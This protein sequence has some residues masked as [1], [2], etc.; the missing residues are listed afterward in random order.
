ATDSTLKGIRTSFDQQAVTVTAEVTGALK[1]AFTDAILRVYF[2]GMFVVVAG[3][4]VTLFLP[5]L[6][7]RK[8]SGASVVG[9]SE[10]GAAPSAGP[11]TP[12]PAA[13][14]PPPTPT[15]EEA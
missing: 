6:A 1:K 2:W 8:R 13:S 5:E 15:S 7:L 3:F 10:G 4:I 11:V 14:A 12:G 9:A